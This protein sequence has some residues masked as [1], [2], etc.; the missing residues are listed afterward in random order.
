MMY[1]IGSNQHYSMFGRPGYFGFSASPMCCSWNAAVPNDARMNDMRLGIILHRRYAKEQEQNEM[2]LG[3][4]ASVSEADGKSTLVFASDKTGTENAFTA[5][6]TGESAVT[7]GLEE[8]QQ[9]R[10][11]REIHRQRRPGAGIPEQRH[12]AAGRRF[13]RH[14]DR[15]GQH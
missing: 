7:V 14:P 2:N 10:D 15:G 8:K 5:H 6:L 3:I 12:K 11:A 1:G 4:T 9:A 13:G